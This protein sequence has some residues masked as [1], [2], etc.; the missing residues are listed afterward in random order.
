MLRIPK[1]DENPAGYKMPSI[2][3][4]EP[5][6]AFISRTMRQPNVRARLPMRA[7]PPK[8]ERKGWEDNAFKVSL[9]NM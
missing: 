2:I 1:I 7:K 5:Q 8:V 6:E 3:I 4:M 9:T